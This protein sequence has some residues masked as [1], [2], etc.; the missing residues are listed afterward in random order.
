MDTVA[1]HEEKGVRLAMFSGSTLEGLAGAGA[2]VLSI[3]ALIGL[4]P[5]YLVAIATLAVGF[6]LL[7]EGSASSARLA[8]AVH[9]A[10]AG[11]TTL[12]ELGGGISMEYFGGIAGLALGIL[13]LAGLIP[14]VLLPVA[15]IVYGVVHFFG[16]AVTAN[17]RI[18]SFA[19]QPENIRR[20]IEAS[21]RGAAG[22]QGLIGIGGAVLGI[23]ALI[24]MVPLTLTIIAML[25]FGVADLIRSP[26]IAL[27]ASKIH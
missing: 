20:L 23:L 11:K 21:A 2:V 16:S 25:A 10:T 6:A 22:I 5:F 14:A 4:F 13:S 18:W 8:R 12:G 17:V 26:V 9:E 3:L 7:M 15:A 24:G 1:V 19:D 27:R